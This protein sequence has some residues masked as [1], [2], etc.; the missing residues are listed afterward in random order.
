MCTGTK[1][2]FSQCIGVKIKSVT[3]NQVKVINTVKKNSQKISD[4]KRNTAK[5]FN[6]FTSLIVDR[7]DSCEQIHK[8]ECEYKNSELEKNVKHLGAKINAL[9]ETSE[10]LHC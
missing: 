4:L 5:R 1:A 10:E 2:D 3:N 6:E 8:A 9:G 7:M